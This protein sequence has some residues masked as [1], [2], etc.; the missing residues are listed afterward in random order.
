MY[1][2]V[3][4][5]YIYMYIL[6]RFFSI[7]G[8]YKVLNIVQYTVGPCCLPKSSFCLHH[9]QHGASDFTLEHGVHFS[10]SQLKQKQNA[11][12]STPCCTQ[13]LRP[14]AHEPHPWC[15]PLHH[16]LGPKARGS[17]CALS[18]PSAGSNLPFPSSLLIILYPK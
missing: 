17:S 6:F 18:L 12:I 9:L 8:Y 16:A 4:Q 10:E 14:T 11:S 1:S 7:I 2:K 15:L 3:I 13:F 5:F